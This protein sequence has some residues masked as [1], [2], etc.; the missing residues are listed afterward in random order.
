MDM[1]HK[2]SRLKLSEALIRRGHTVT[3]YIVKKLGEKKPDSDYIISVP[4]VPL[5]IFSGIFYGL[6]VFFYFPILLKRSKADII[7][8]DCTKVWIPFV[9]PLKMLK[10]PIILDIRTLPVENENLF[11]FK[12]S[13]YLSK[14]IVDGVT[15]ITPELYETIK[16][17]YHLN[18]NNIGFWSSGVSIEDFNKPHIQNNLKLSFINND[19]VIVY[20]GDYDSQTR[21][22]ENIIRAVGKLD[23]QIKNKVGVLIIGM[24]PKIIHELSELGVKEGIREQ[25]KIL[26]KIMYN[27]VID[28]LQFADVGI[29]PLP[30]D[31][32]WWHVSAPLKTLEYLAAGK[33][34][35]V[36]DIPFHRRIFEK[37]NCGVL[38]DSSSPE[39][40]A[41][42]ITELYKN[43]N[44]LKKMGSEGRAIA[45]KYY[46]WDIMAKAVED[47]CNELR[48]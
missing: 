45:E 19:L 37:G 24:P 39:I 21:K 44:N 31:L 2:T 11:F 22:I 7:I 12:I 28:Y 10:K 18:F 43:K 17:M 1:P 36:T 4:T 23:P 29:I 3:L 35:I 41:Q 8:I 15:A 16:E 46:T 27:E 26:P 34:I 6:I 20:H 25:V 47:F 5:P 40:I 38:I 14:Y 9:I 33:P 30:P 13:M 32:I 48:K 42:A